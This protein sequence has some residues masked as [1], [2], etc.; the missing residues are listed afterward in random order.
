M[1]AKANRLFD[2]KENKRKYLKSA[3][4]KSRQLQV[5]KHV[6]DKENKKQKEEEFKQFWKLRNDELL[7]AEEQEKEEGK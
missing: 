3:I 1:E 5:D 6:E 4:D 7:V 2:E